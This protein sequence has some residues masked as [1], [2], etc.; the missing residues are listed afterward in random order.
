MADEEH[1]IHDV[2]TGPY[3]AA[4]AP[5]VIERS[6]SNG[7]SQTDD[8]CAPFLSPPR[9]WAPRAARG[10]VSVAL[11]TRFHGYE[12]EV[13]GQ[14]FFNLIKDR[15]SLQVLI[16]DP[17]AST[18]APLDSGASCGRALRGIAIGSF[19]RQPKRPQASGLRG[20]GRPRFV[21]FCRCF[22]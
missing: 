5:S 11:D 18:R 2:A 8:S 15:S 16:T 4:M 21:E 12:G 14:Y 7:T 1:E 13:L 9:R 17:A 22:A 3:W 19:L 20:L 10:V 6:G